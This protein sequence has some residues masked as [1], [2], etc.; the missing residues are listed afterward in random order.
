MRIDLKAKISKL[1]NDLPI[2]DQEI[3]QLEQVIIDDSANLKLLKGTTFALERAS[4][5]PTLEQIISNYKSQISQSKRERN[6]NISDINSLSQKLDALDKDNFQSDILIN[7]EQERKILENQLQKFNEPQVKTLPI[8][9]TK[10]E[11]IKPKTLVPILLGIIMG[12]ITS[13]LL[14]FI[15]NFVKSFRYSQA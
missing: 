6:N 11:N 2:I 1:K 10:T 5:S 9:I 3:S 13:F 8:G 12:F 15:R 7:Q 4:N 14:I